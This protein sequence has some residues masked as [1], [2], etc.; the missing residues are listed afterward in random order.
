MAFQ[1]RLTAPNNGANNDKLMYPAIHDGSSHKVKLNNKTDE[2]VN[3]LGKM[4]SQY[5]IQV[6]GA[7]DRVILYC[8]DAQ[9]KWP[10]VQYKYD[11]DTFWGEWHDIALVYTGTNMQ[12]YV[13][14][15]AGEATPGRVMHQ[16]DTRLYLN[17]MHPVSLQSDTILKR[18]Q[19]TRQME[20]V[21]NTPHWIR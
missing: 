9:D 7:N 4:D 14:G 6:D 17:L 2:V 1:G 18:V 12:L 15:K 20:T 11:A 13:D 21:L 8:C 16:M 5:G 3:I 10:E 19:T